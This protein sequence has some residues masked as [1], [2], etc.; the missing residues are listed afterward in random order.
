LQEG[1]LIA[2]VADRDMSRN[3]IEVDFIGGIA[4]MPS[5][6]AILAINTG[7]PLITAYIRYTENGIK[8][9]FDQV[10]IPTNLQNENEKISAVTQLMA[11]NFAKH[12]KESPVDWHMLQRIWVDEEN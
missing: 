4:K 1:K 3:G 2:L 12:I 10:I 5:G 8:I 11:N 9:I 6:P 7:A